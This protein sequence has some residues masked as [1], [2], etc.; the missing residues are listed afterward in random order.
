M[1][2]DLHKDVI[3]LC[4]PSQHSEMETYGL[5]VSIH[6]SSWQESEAIRWPLSKPSEFSRFRLVSDVLV[7]LT[8]SISTSC[9][10]FVFQ[11]LMDPV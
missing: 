10:M 11:C 6:S 5:F 2:W 1:A 9:V 7:E 4:A 3:R 8:I